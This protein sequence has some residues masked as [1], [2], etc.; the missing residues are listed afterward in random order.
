MT[1]KYFGGETFRNAERV[2]NRLAAF[3]ADGR[4]DEVDFRPLPGILFFEPFSSAQKNRVPEV[5]TNISRKR[6]PKALKG[7]CFQDGLTEDI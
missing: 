5:K 4:N 1:E 7:A 2:S 3:T 6:G